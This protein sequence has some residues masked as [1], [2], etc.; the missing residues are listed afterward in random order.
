MA[1]EPGAR[2]GA[3]AKTTGRLSARNRTASR[4]EAAAGGLEV[5]E[6]IGR[7]ARTVRRSLEDRGPAILEAHI[8]RVERMAKES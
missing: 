5:G 6:M 8:A 2:R 3:R 4:L 1:C 7:G